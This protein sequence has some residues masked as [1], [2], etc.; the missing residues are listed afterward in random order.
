MW[1]NKGMK[2]KSYRM[3]GIVVVLFIAIFYLSGKQNKALAE[4]TSTS[5]DL[6]YGDY[7][8]KILED[9]TVSITGY[10]G[11][12]SELH[13]PDTI[14]GKKITV[15]GEFA[16][17]HNKKLTKVVLPKELKIIG[18]SAFRHCYNLNEV[19]M[20]DGLLEIG[21]YSFLLAD[22]SSLSIPDTVKEIGEQAFAAN[23]NLI[24]VKLSKR[25]EVIQT[26]VFYCCMKLNN[27]YI[28]K[29]VT[30]I[31]EQAFGY[32]DNLHTL[33]SDE[34]F[35]TG[36]E[37]MIIPPNIK[38]IGGSIFEECNIKN[39]IVLNKDC[40]IGFLGSA[41]NIYCEKDSAVYKYAFLSGYYKEWK[42]VKKISLSKSTLELIVNKKNTDKLTV[43]YAPKD[44]IIQQ[45]I[46]SSSNPKVATVDQQGN[47]K[48]VGKGSAKITARTVEGSNISKSCTVNVQTEVTKVV[49]NK[50]KATLCTTGT[51]TIQLSASISPKN[52]SNKK[53]TWKSSNTKVAT[54]D[55]KG[56]VTAKGPG[57]VSIT[58]TSNNYKATCKVTVTPAAQKGLKAYGQKSNEIKL[59]WSKVAGVSGY[60]I[61]RY[62]GK[63]KKYVKI[64]DTKSNT[65]TVKKVSGSKGKQL[66]SGTYYTFKVTPY[67]ISENKKI[68]GTSAK[69]RTSTA[70]KATTITK[71][72]K[73]YK[74]GKCGITIK[75][76]EIS[77]ATGYK[78]YLSTKKRSGYKCIKTLSGKKRTSYTKYGL[79]KNKT[80][81]IK[82]RVLKKAEKTTIQSDYSKVKKVR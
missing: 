53:V 72:T 23:I 58:A 8:Y 79:S 5:T 25:L 40:S 17:Y 68:Y 76:K 54:V 28:P 55:S 22:L 74:K 64:K 69:V 12:A 9:G 77:G 51:K 52:V 39:Y 26:K 50:S 27:L 81:Y 46:W 65:Y 47:V 10:K 48:A 73:V 59:K 16:F 31:D 19:K 42:P 15:I 24:D 7:T 6:T 30:R 75:W 80:Y 78:V 35:Y 61:Y 82:I 62:D 66:A 60:S 70:T 20:F 18:K 14:N 13:M 45:V 1:G 56:K 71:G 44:S 49:L 34:V 43:T 67:K 57:I 63:Q 29:S 33:L 2:K 41:G 4:K 36:K 37:F 3:I 38:E 32:C 11:N 21:E